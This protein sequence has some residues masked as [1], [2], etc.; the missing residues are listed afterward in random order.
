[1]DN[2]QNPSILDIQSQQLLSANRVVESTCYAVCTEV[3]LRCQKLARN[4]E[5]LAKFD[6]IILNLNIKFYYKVSTVKS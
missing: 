5:S 6:N 3:M 4:T 2:H 1:M